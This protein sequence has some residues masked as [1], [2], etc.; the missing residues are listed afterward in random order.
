MTESFSNTECKLN[1]DGMKKLQIT[2]LKPIIKLWFRQELSTIIKAIKWIV[3]GKVGQ[4][5]S[6]LTD[7]FKE[8]SPT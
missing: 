8:T 7:R 4:K 6:H 2:I 5:T 1:V 3:E